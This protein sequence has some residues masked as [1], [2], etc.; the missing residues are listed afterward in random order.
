[1][2]AAALSQAQQQRAQAE[3]MPPPPAPAASSHGHGSHG[4][5]AHSASASASASAALEE[6][7][8]DAARL[9]LE[10][11]TGLLVAH[12]GAYGRTLPA[13][14]AP[15]PMGEAGGEAGVLA[16]PVASVVGSG[17]ATAAAREWR[18]WVAEEVLPLAS[19]AA[20]LLSAPAPA[21]ASG[22]V[23][24]AGAS[25]APPQSPDAGRCARAL[26]SRVLSL[27]PAAFAG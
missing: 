18:A 23:A 24:G 19:R 3:A 22:A 11:G 25:G 26:E 17:A 15:Q 16:A 5:H 4:A 27:L 13:P 10:M 8:S 6:E 14:A 7:A 20:Q 9:A 21:A 1:M 12:V 2:A